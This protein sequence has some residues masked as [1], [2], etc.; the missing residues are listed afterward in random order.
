SKELSNYLQKRTSSYPVLIKP[1]KGFRGR[2]IAIAENLSQLKRL[3]LPN[4]KAKKDFMI[5]PILDQNEYRILVVNNEVVLMHSKANP[6]VMGDGV[7]TIKQLLAPILDIAKDET[8]I[9]W[10]HTKK[11]TKPSSILTKGETFEYHLT[12][13]PTT[14][15]YETENMPLPVKKWAL[16]LAKD[17]S[18]PV[19]GI[20]VFIPGPL[21][22][23]SRYTI[24]E[25]NSNPGVDYL[26]TYCNDNRSPFLIFEK[27][28]QDYFKV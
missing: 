5:Q 18:S 11:R 15:Y 3:A 6:S 28:L 20:D 26:I 25:L 27:V 9:S 14:T 23:T 7:A 1:D 4:Y 24:I 13:K 12:K 17:I 22:E 10:Q 2:G 16:K 19:V 8:F 21:S